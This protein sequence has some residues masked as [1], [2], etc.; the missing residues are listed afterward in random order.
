MPK[1]FTP[2]TLN[3]A[4]RQL[5]ERKIDFE[6]RQ[7][8]AHADTV[9]ERLSHIAGYVAFKEKA[10]SSTL[11]KT[12]IVLEVN[13]E[14]TRMV[15]RG[16]LS[17]CLYDL[18]LYLYPYYKLIQ[19]KRCINKLLIAFK[20]IYD[21]TNYDIEYYLSVLRRLANTFNKAFS[22]KVTDDF[23]RKK[24]VKDNKRTNMKSTLMSSKW[25]VILSTDTVFITKIWYFERFRTFGFGFYLPYCKLLLIIRI[26]RFIYGFHCLNCV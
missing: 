17:E 18:T 10:S 15:S 1:S 3:A 24:H 23:N 12:A 22:K 21:Y 7:A 19:D 26:N 16:E 5:K 20:M 13:S 2:Q 11:D 14:F 6:S 25:D 9:V 4:P 8:D